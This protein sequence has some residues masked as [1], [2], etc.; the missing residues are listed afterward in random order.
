VLASFGLLLRTLAL[1]RHARRQA[2]GSAAAAAAINRGRG[3]P[4]FIHQSQRLFCIC[5]WSVISLA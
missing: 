1:S 3:R 2:P 5:H 4:C